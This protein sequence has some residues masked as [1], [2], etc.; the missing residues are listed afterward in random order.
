VY[1]TILTPADLH[2]V[3]KDEMGGTCLDRR[4]LKV[5]TILTLSVPNLFLNFS[6]PCM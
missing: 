5:A 1:D 3:I 4:L 6:T 2:I